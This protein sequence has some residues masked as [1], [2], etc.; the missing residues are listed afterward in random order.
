MVVLEHL[1]E[2]SILA[3][4]DKRFM[5][6]HIYTYTGSILVSINPYKPMNIYTAEVGRQYNSQPLGARPPHIYAL[7]DT[8]YR[9]MCIG[10]CMGVSFAHLLE[11]RYVCSFV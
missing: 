5:G 6:N 2:A 11:R 9:G 7:A 10:V 4:L 1:H 8:A 3:N